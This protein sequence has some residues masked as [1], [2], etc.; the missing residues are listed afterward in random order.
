MPMMPPG[1]APTQQPFF[2]QVASPA[3]PSPLGG[4]VSE[5]ADFAARLDPRR[6]MATA[7]AAWEQAT[8]VENGEWSRLRQW[9]DERDAAVA[10]GRPI[11]PE[12][13]GG[14]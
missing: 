3:S 9:F 8:G 1:A 12:P 7:G 13:E 10:A 6:A 4:E 2:Q 5:V 11:P 14:K